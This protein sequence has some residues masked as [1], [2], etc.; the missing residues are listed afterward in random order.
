LLREAQVEPPRRIVVAS[1]EG[2]KQTV[3]SGLGVAL[4]PALAVAGDLER[5]SL[6]LVGLRAD[7]PTVEWGV[8]TTGRERSPV[9]DQL[10][11]ALMTT[12]TDA[13]RPSSRPKTA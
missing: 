12:H 5:G 1:L 10:V 7:L 2:V 3:M 9:V 11:T 4:V 8:V 13:K 6:A